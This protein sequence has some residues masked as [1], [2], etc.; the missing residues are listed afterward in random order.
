MKTS[1]V[2]ALTLFTCCGLAA[3][4][5]AAVSFGTATNY[6]AAQ[7]PSGVAIADFTGDGKADFAVTVDT[8]DRL[9]VFPGNGAGGFGAPLTTFLPAGG[10]AGEVAAADFDR[11][12]DIDIAICEQNSGT[13]LIYSNTAGTFAL[14]A[15]ITAGSNPRNIKSADIN[16]DQR[17]DLVLANR[18]SDNAT[19]AI[20]GLA[21][22]TSTNIATG[23]EPLGI[24][25]GDI[26]GDNDL[27]LAIANHRTRSVSVFSNAGTG[28]FALAQT[29]AVNA[30][31]RPDGVALVQVAGS[32]LPEVAAVI[33]DDVVGSFVSVY[34]N[35]AGTLAPGAVNYATSGSN[36]GVI[37]ASDFDADGICDVVVT[38]S[39]SGSVSVLAGTGTGFAAPLVLATG[40]TPTAIA[41]G[42]LDADVLPDLVI[43][44][45]DANTVTVFLNTGTPPAP[46]CDSID[47][48]ND[49]SIF[50]PQDFEAFLSVYS[51]GPCIPATA[52]CND[53]DF[54]ND[55]SIFDPQDINSFL[56]VYSE[57]PCF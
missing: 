57:G 50:D 6:P 39:D 37:L 20:N 49:T 16:G 48:N 13:V 4:V 41:T 45:S 44:N 51:E 38:N 11:D 17:P 30:V 3:T 21:G 27:D 32:V 46:V 25:L 15:T 31:F 54:N 53:I 35:N 28:T 9:L 47:F 12:N 24:A 55:T 14:S 18:D 36:S 52:T 34:A 8:Q 19:V 42:R 23:E 2:C 5:P 7:R 10:G 56:S 43:A 29:L 40:T 22:W 33:S 26:D 1:H